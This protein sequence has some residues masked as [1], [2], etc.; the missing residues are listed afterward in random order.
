MGG[1]EA[2]T[3]AD[4]LIVDFQSEIQT[5]QCVIVAVPSDHL[6]YRP[7]AKAKTGLG[8]VRHITLEDEWLLNCI[9][10]GAFTPPPDDPDACGDHEPGRR[11]R[12][13]QRTSSRSP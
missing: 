1:Q 2:K 4:F 7:E 9:A 10:S 11:Y 13:L 5:T 3:I 8:L 6:D 12:P